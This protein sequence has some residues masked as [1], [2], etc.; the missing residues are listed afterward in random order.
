MQRWLQVLWLIALFLLPAGIG[1]AISRVA[2]GSWTSRWFIV[3][4]L[5]GLLLLALCAL[6]RATPR[7]ALTVTFDRAHVQ[8]P[9]V[10]DQGKVV[11][12]SRYFHFQVHSEAPVRQCEARLIRVEREVSGGGYEMV[13]EFK[14]PVHLTLD[15]VEG[16]R[17]PL[18]EPQL[19]ARINLIFSQSNVVGGAML[20]VPSHAPHGNLT[21]LLQGKYRL[22]VRVSAEGV[23]D[24]E[25]RFIVRVT[26]MWSG[27]D[28]AVD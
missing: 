3:G 27:L 18:I 24:V 15:S 9:A 8:T 23:E 11:A 26:G 6:W 1:G 13:P 10:V 21:T 12:Q 2:S 17:W 5:G 16:L 20:C 19:P 4:L 28:V 25:G 14:P 22:T 7:S